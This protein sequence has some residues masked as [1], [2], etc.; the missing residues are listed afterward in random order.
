MNT[1]A[2]PADTTSLDGSLRLAERRPLHL[3]VL[4][5]AY[6]E[7]ANLGKLLSFLRTYEDVSLHG[8]IR[9]DVWVDV[10]GSS[11]RTP[12]IAHDLARRWDRLHVVDTGDRDGLIRALDRMLRLARGDLFLRMDADVSLTS[13]TLD[14]LLRV[15]LTTPAGI[16]GARIVPT[17]SPS[18]IVNRLSRA[19]YS[20]HHRV[21]LRSA[22]TTLV[23][24]CRAAPIRLRLDSPTDDQELQCQVTAV[25]G[26]AAYAPTA[27][28]TVAPP[29]NVRNF[30]MQRIRTIQH[31][32]LHRRRGYATSAT[33]S[34]VNVF[35]AL[36]DELRESDHP[37][38]LLL[39][40]GVEGLAR[41]AARWLSLF[42]SEAPFQWKQ[43]DDTKQPS[44]SFP[45]VAASDV[46]RAS[47]EPVPMLTR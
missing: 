28:V 23:Q 38:D 16:V 15:M 25:S 30:L 44:W 17:R 35:P 47:E 14:E 41:V 46:T 24:L 3:A 29:T 9:V 40:L 34:V 10:S 37:L 8:P 26:P 22:K 1:Q 36:V 6:N 39:F 13:S 5:P 32:N 21:C 42:G 2:R 4:I 20:V 18:P 7:E 43:I 27:I 31:I 45:S 11:D 19:E 33:D 12:A